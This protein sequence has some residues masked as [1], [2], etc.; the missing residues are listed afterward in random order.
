M[1]KIDPVVVSFIGDLDITRQKE[2]REKLKSI[3]HTPHVVVDMSGVRYIDSTTLAAF[4][5]KRR[6]RKDRG[7]PPARMVLV[8]EQIKRIL[9]VTALDL[10]WPIHDTLA[11][12]IAAF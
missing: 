5:S 7:L 9:K 4:A 3:E 11:E 2:V 8:S 6:D 1:T 12:A 10:I